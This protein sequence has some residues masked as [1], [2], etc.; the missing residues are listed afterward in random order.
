M[1]EGLA[2]ARR[3]RATTWLCALWAA[4][5]LVQI[6]EIW[7][8]WVLPN[9][10]MGDVY[11]VYE[12]WSLQAHNGGIVGITEP[13][14]YP[15]VAL[16]PML[17]PRLLW[18][19]EDYTLAW[20]V[21]VALLNAIAFAVLLRDASSP[22]RRAA[23][24]FWIAFLACFGPVAFF[25]IDGVTVPLAVLAV[26]F[27]LRYPAVASVLLTVGA[28]I[29]IWPGA[30]LLAA[31]AVMRKT[32]ALLVAAV[33]VSLIVI[34]VVI[35]GGGAT[36]LFGFLTM[37]SDR[38][39]QAEAP[40]STPWLWGAAAHVPGTGV[41]FNGEIITFQ[42]TGAGTEVAAALMTP[43]LVIVALALAVFA[44]FR[45]R[46]GVSVHAL[47][48][49]LALA[50]VLSFIVFNKVGSPQFQVW[51]IAPIV[52]WLLW[53]RR[54]ARPYAIATLAAALL[55]QLVYP[56]MYDRFVLADSLPVLVMTARNLLLVVM[57]A[58]SCVHLARLRPVRVLQPHNTGV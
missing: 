31:I 48:P 47:L 53:D 19:I 40:A 46:A 50:M 24:A 30:V 17:A 25:R 2:D 11:N 52:L 29:K 27:L 34:G 49:P 36:N 33:G 44:W 10:P 41:V 26:L 32:R 39:M 51:L 6:L 8:G 22:A 58:A 23:A 35:A 5:V 37:Q 18:G 54:R 16:L 4:F 12:I 28:W 15:P 13:W 14:V 21:M 20:A 56:L 42:V 1:A 38:G 3:R 57:L 7:L 9:Q 45:A 55:T 43:L